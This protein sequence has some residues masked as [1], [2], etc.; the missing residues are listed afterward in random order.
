MDEEQVRELLGRYRPVGPVKTLRQRALAPRVRALAP[1]WPWA[2]A[3][4][5]LM[6]ASVGFHVATNRAAVGHALPPSPASEEALTTALG[7]DEEARSVARSIVA[8]Q[9]FR[10]W[11]AG[12][13]TDGSLE[14]LL[15]GVN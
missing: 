15:N 6:A 2:A 14:E 1:A 11:L 8:E 13:G 10:A 3:A 5:A 4:A 12:D 7:G 9:A